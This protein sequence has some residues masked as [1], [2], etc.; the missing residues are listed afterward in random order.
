MDPRQRRDR[1]GVSLVELMIAMSIFALVMLGVVGTWRKTQEAYFVG[2]EAAEVQQNVRAAIDFIVRELR[3]TGRDVTLCAFDF[4]NVSQDCDAG[5]RTACQAKLGG[6][7]NNGN[8]CLLNFAI[9]ATDATISTIRIRSDRNA[10]G[11]IV[12]RPN[13]DGDAGEEDVIYALAAAGN[14]P[15]G[16]P[17][18]CITRDDGS[19][20]VAMV[21]VDITGFTLTYFP[22]PGFAPCNASPPQNPCPAFTLPMT[23]DQADNV[24]EIRVVVT[25]RQV[26][27]GQEVRKTLATNVVLPNRR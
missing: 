16:I 10:N 21:A 3:S 5:K 2:S 1:S 27:A 24:A 9:P 19:G 14:C 7:W 15:S 26:T 12:G 13:T 17:G 20:P 11:R 6:N 23:Q 22:R 4:Q 8:G 25:A 18:A